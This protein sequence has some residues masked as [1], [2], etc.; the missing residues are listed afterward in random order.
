MLRDPESVSEPGWLAVRFLAMPPLS[1]P[2]VRRG[3]FHNSRLHEQRCDSPR[4]LVEGV[5]FVPDVFGLRAL[6]H[7]DHL[8]GQLIVVIH[9]QWAIIEADFDSSK[10][11]HG[12]ANVGLHA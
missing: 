5:G 12:V 10:Q 2:V 6:T 11:T 1:A 3:C 9:Q 4:A 7:T 8:A